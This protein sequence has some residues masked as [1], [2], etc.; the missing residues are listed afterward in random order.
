MHL[1][2]T[3]VAIPAVCC[4]IAWVVVTVRRLCVPERAPYRYHAQPL[5]LQPCEAGMPER[6]PMPVGVREIREHQ[7]RMLQEQHYVR[8]CYEDGFSRGL[9]AAWS[10]ELWRRRN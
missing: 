9:P 10:E 8:Y 1:Y 3:L 5:V 4:M 7:R 2:F 6:A